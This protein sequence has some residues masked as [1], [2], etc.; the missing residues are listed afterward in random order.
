VIALQQARARYS[1]AVNTRKLREQVLADDQKKFTFGTATFTTLIV[2]Q[3]TLAAAQ[4]TEVTALSAY[5]RARTGLD[6]VLGET[7]E[8]NNVSLDEG[9]TGSAG[10]AK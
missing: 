4:L 1:T 3:R 9:I 10:N 5:A 2:D 8:K 7:L 6:Q